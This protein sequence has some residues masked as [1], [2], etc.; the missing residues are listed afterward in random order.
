MQFFS[1]FFFLVSFSAVFFYRATNV[2]ALN[3]DTMFKP[4]DCTVWYIISLLILLFTFVLKLSFRRESNAVKDVSTLL[5]SVGAF[6]QQSIHIKASTVSSR[7][8][9]L[10]LIISSFLLY[11]FYTSQ[12]VSM[13]VE[14]KHETDIKTIVDLAESDVSIGFLESVPIRFLLSV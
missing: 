13:L 2:N 4:F 14:S 6:C 10:C 3:V 1:R 8:L 7:S 5:I 9:I 11:N 12:L